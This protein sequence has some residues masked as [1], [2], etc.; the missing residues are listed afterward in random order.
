M[1]LRRRKKNKDDVLVFVKY[2]IESIVYECPYCNDTLMKWMTSLPGEHACYK[3]DR[4][5][6]FKFIYES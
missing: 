6:N 4:P 1:N 3:C 5:L 2:H